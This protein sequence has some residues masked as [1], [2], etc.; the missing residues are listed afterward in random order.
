MKTDLTP[1][2]MPPEALA[3]VRAARGVV[4]DL[5][6]NLYQSPIVLAQ[7]F[8]GLLVSAAEADNLA[9]MPHA[10]V[11]AGAYRARDDL[12]AALEE[13]KRADALLFGLIPKCPKVE[14]L[15]ARRNAALEKGE[16][17]PHEPTLA[18]MHGARVALA[19]A[20]LTMSDEDILARLREA[21]GPMVRQS[22]APPA[23]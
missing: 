22:E 2:P 8:L 14:A 19:A 23:V 13:I 9:E 6:D 7:S 16:E 20:G 15:I 21:G 17:P 11:A 12:E 5:H 1:A 18:E 3:A 4:S 10:A